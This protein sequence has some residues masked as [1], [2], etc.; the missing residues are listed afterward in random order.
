M[1]PKVHL[2]L[3]PEHRL[4]YGI[5]FITDD[6][7]STQKKYLENPPVI[8]YL[9]SDGN[10]SEKVDDIA[11]FKTLQE[12]QDF[13]DSWLPKKEWLTIDE[14][15]SAKNEKEALDLSIEHWKQICIADYEDLKKAKEK[16]EVSIMNLHCALCQYHKATGRC[17]DCILKDDGVCCQEW[18]KVAQNEN[19]LS[20]DQQ[21]LEFKKACI[22]MLN[23]LITERNKMVTYNIDGKEFSEETIKKALKKY[24][25]FKEK[26]EKR[27]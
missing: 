4:C 15:K 22:Q 17:D 2:R 27:T 11:L 26:V 7:E 3:R 19:G 25:D 14:I 6:L 10:L 24:C 20:T 12:A 13:L 23:R 9:Q 21:K 5:Y 16:D 1:N 8:W 18:R